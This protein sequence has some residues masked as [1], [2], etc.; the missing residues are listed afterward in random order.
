M[1]INEAKDML[2]TIM[3]A[4]ED[5]GG[6]YNCVECPFHNITT[7]SDCPFDECPGIW[8]LRGESFACER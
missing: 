7:G 8:E 3:E 5:A 2:L 1:S 4:V 6:C